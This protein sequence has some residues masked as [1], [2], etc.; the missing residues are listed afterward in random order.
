MSNNKNSRI[1]FRKNPYRGIFREIA[2]DFNITP[3]AVHNAWRRNNTKIIRAV[4]KSLKKRTE[5]LLLKE[6][7]I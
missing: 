7:L 5:V 4:K 6:S 2:S 1:N 3:Q